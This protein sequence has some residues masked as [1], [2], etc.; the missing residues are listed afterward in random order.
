MTLPHHTDLARD[1]KPRPD[2]IRAAEAHARGNTGWFPGRIEWTRGNIARLIM[3]VAM[4]A[5][6]LFVLATCLAQV[7]TTDPSTPRGAAN[8]YFA[9]LQAGDDA[10]VSELECANLYN[11]AGRDVVAEALR[12]DGGSA[13]PYSLGPEYGD[14][15]YHWFDFVVGGRARG[16][17]SVKQV[18]DEDRYMVCDFLDVQY[19]R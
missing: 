1:N 11:E 14:S 2:S 6:S 15:Y 9:A 18:R 17:I 7:S 4:A 19:R 5:S 16:T 10:A 3:V 8:A 13:R 12:S